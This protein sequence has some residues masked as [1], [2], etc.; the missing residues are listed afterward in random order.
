MRVFITQSTSTLEHWRF[1]AADDVESIEVD[2]YI[3]FSAPE[4]LADGR[5]RSVIR[6]YLPPRIGQP[7]AHDM[8]YRGQHPAVHI[9]VLWSERRDQRMLAI[10]AALFLRNREMLEQLVAVAESR[11]RV[12]FWCRSA[13][14][15]KELQQALDD[16]AVAVQFGSAWKA[17][18]GQVVP[19][20]PTGA[21]DW[22]TL[23]AGHPIK[24]TA[25]G[26]GLG[27]IIPRAARNGDV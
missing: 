25:K 2:M 23:A 22:E 24:S 20:T 19:C 16:A 13:E 26:H 21:V 27:L 14:H 18:P 6:F 3:E 5:D 4:Y 12:E 10:L 7:R 8:R 17:S 15:A 9:C 11:G 1:T